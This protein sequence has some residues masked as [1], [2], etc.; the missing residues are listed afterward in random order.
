MN[1]LLTIGL[2]LATAATTFAKSTDTRPNIIF[3]LPDDQRY[4]AMGF[5]GTFPWLETP[6]IDRIAQQG[7][8][9]TNGYYK[10]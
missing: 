1:R 10:Y 6:N 5:M 4:D 3:I 9:F 7:A 8:K 2:L